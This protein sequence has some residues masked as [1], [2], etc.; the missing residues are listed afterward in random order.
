V[1]ST[2]DFDGQIISFPGH[3]LIQ[4]EPHRTYVDERSNIKEVKTQ[5]KTAFGVFQTVLYIQT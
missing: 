5:V 3:G 1:S 4:V 2:R